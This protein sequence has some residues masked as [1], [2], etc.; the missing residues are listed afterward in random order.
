[1]KQKLEKDLLLLQE[2]LEQVQNSSTY[3]NDEFEKIKEELNN[4]NILVSQLEQELNSLRETSALHQLTMVAREGEVKQL[5]QEVEKNLAIERELKSL[6][7]SYERQQLMLSSKE[8]KLSSVEEQLQHKDVRLK[9]CNKQFY[10]FRV[11]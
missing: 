5:K 9:N 3:R 4:S 10:H 7:E 8:E 11:Q 2:A 6:Q 1:M